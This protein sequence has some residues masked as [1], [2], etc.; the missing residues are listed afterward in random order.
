MLRNKQHIQIFIY[1][2]YNKQK[3]MNEK[4]H[5]FADSSVLIT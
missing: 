4:V 1:V 5:A 2:D 3:L